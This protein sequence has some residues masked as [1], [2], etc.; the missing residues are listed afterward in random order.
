MTQARLI[1]GKASAAKVL[2]QVR[3]EV[4]SLKADGISPALA[5]ILVGD[6]PAS[7][8]YVR[9]KIL[10]AEE[11]GIRSFEYRLPADSSQARVLAVIA[12][13]NA[14]PSVNGILLQLPL[15]AH[16]EEACALQ[17]IDPAK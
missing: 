15:P 5:V 10:R 3:D 9:N 16:R 13:L 14:D 2:Q 11:A 8:V 7:E 17:A 6:D 1:D 4:Q 12:G